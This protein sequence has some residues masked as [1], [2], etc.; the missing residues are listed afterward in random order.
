MQEQTN[1]RKNDLTDERTQR[2][3]HTTAPVS[4]SISKLYEPQINL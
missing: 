3:L 1:E 2:S 4:E